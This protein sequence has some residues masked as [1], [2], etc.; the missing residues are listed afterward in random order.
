LIVP[1]AI[2]V[3]PLKAKVKHRDTTSPTPHY[4]FKFE[5]TFCVRGVVSPLLSNI[6][7][8]EVDQML[9]R[10]AEVTR[11]GRFR[12]LEYARFADD[13]VVLVDIQYGPPE[14]LRQVN[15]RLREEFARLG[16]EINEEKSRC[17]DLRKGESFGFL[18]FDFRR[19]RARTGNWRVQLTPRLKKRTALLRNLKEVFRRYRSQPVGRVI[20]IINPILRGWVNYFA[21]G[22]SSKCFRMIQRWAEL[23]VRRHMMQARKRRGFGWERWSTRW[24]YEH[25]KLFNA[26][27]LKRFAPKAV[28]A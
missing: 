16:V 10:A 7:L 5:I 25:L 27:R 8:N 4:P 3:L 23:K 18:G 11:R 28:P 19:I 13:L 9:E 21:V 26:Y 24:L 20:E 14:L 6:Y 15:Q 22:H 17:V 12:Y 1:F 2:N